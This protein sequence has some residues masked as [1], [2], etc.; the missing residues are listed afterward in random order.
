MTK[1]DQPPEV[2]APRVFQKLTERDHLMLDHLHAQWAKELPPPGHARHGES[3]KPGRRY[4]RDDTEEHGPRGKRAILGE[5]PPDHVPG[6]HITADGD[7][8]E[9]PDPRT[10]FAPFVEYSH[11][12]ALTTARIVARQI[13]ALPVFTEEE[14]RA[15]AAKLRADFSRAVRKAEV[16]HINSRPRAAFVDAFIGTDH[17]A[18]GGDREATASN[19]AQYFAN[20]DGF[21]VTGNSMG[22][23]TWQLRERFAPRHDFVWAPSSKIQWVASDQPCRIA[24]PKPRKP[25]KPKPAETRKVRAHRRACRDRRGF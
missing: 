1:H 20:T 2:D 19:V 13:D 11:P 3:N 15:A 9:G 18:P 5:P 16:V 7:R 14:A 12:D 22:K 10:G 6:F 24:L 17:G 8:V 23:T 21:L 4:E 25:R